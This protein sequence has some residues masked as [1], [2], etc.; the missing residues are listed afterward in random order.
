MP[1]LLGAYF[2]TKY[3][4]LRSSRVHRDMKKMLW[5][6]KKGGLSSSERCSCWSVTRTGLTMWPVGQ[7]QVEISPGDQT[8][9]S[10]L[11]NKEWG[12]VT[13][14]TGYLCSLWGTPRHPT[15]RTVTKNPLGVSRAGKKTWF[16]DCVLNQSIKPTTEV[17]KKLYFT[18]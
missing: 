15:T 11:K 12:G 9:T 13:E 16:H 5:E 6:K 2:P 18:F 10:A 1:S 17:K 3:F 8:K 7:T 4:G 14:M